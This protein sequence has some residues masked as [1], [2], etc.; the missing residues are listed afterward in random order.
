MAR[1]VRVAEREARERERGLRDDMV[2]VRRV[3]GRV[4][5][6]A[7]SFAHSHRPPTAC[8]KEKYYGMSPPG[9]G[10][11]GHKRKAAVF[12]SFASAGETMTLGR[13]LK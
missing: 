6:D 7:A 8:R 13:D 1:D 10:P 5:A 12:S 4:D 11:H 9:S 2:P 3:H